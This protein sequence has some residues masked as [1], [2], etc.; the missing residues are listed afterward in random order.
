[1]PS[2]SKPRTH[3]HTPITG[4]G[5]A[6]IVTIPCSCPSFDHLRS[7]LFLV[8]LTDS[9]SLLIMVLLQL[10]L[11]EPSADGGVADH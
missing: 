5:A 3:L 6:G 11:S 10:F 9:H 7:T 2:S 1:M 8:S 4:T